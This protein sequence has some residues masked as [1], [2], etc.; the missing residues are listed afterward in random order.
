M[1]GRKIIRAIVAGG[2]LLLLLYFIFRNYVLHSALEKIS[3]QLQ[4]KYQLELTT[5]EASFS[6][7]MTVEMRKILICSQDEDTLMSLDTLSATP[8][9]ASLL[10]FNV[11]VKN[12]VMKNGFIRLHCSDSKCNYSTILKGKNEYTVS[13]SGEARHTKVNYA[14][15]F[16]RLFTKAF[17]LAPQNAEMRNLDLRFLTDSFDTHIR[18]PEFNSSVEKME[19]TLEDVKQK[20]SWKMHG[21][22]D[23]ESMRYDATICPLN[24]SARL[25]LIKEFFGITAGFDTVR[26]AL[27]ESDYS[28]NV[29]NMSGEVSAKTFYF[30]HKR[31]SDDTVRMDKAGFNYDLSLT[32]NSIFLDS[33]SSAMLNKIKIHPFFKFT[34]GKSNIYEL[35]L[36][37]DTTPATDFFS[38]LPAGVFDETRDI[39]ADG[40]LQ[41]VLHFKLDSS[42]PDSVEFDSRLSKMKFH[43]RKSGKEN[44]FKMNGEF[45][46]TVYEYEHPYR[47]F[48][49]GPSNPDFTPLDQAGQ[50]LK[51]AILTSEDGSFFF[52]NGFN[53]E[54]FRKSIAENYRRK[55]FVR[56]GS[57]IS[58]QLVKNVFLSRHKTIA[59][60]AEEALMV[61]LIESNRLT[62]KDRMFEVY[63]NIIELGPGIYG[64]G[65]ASRFYFNKK[66][67]ELT[68]SESIFLASLLPHPKWFKYSFDLQGNLKPYLADYYRVVSNFL[69]RKNLITQQEYDA[70]VPNVELKGIA[71]EMVVPS[72]SIPTEDEE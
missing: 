25:P 68:L 35:D 46:H 67:L 54:A 69:L 14:S 65:E 33:T 36:R 15:A 12:L 61:W 50:N 5:G 30:F 7:L 71:H 28:D 18:I 16:N 21:S 47:S 8:S 70:I 55:K 34:S 4:N 64:V 31:I 45:M 44:L 19:G 23:Q 51:N 24:G 37:T 20:H 13:D 56:G 63:L 48:I 66:P 58:M 42:I 40:R 27:D 43:L 11:R 22:F 53:E 10:L 72:D 49:V 32:A 60:K 38:S 3:A 17:D 26:I 52:H 41:Y 59:R 2:L 29:F 39:Q 62:S 57:T 9:I 1:T 6:G